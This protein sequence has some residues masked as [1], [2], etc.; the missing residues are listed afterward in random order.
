MCEYCGCQDV[1][2]IADL[3]REHDAVVALIAEVR[4]AFAAGDAPALAGL[5]RRIATVLEPHTAVEEEGLFPLLTDDFPDHVAVL[6]DEH[7]RVEAVLAAAQ[8]GTPADPGWPAALMDAMELLREHIL[9]EQDGV[10]P[11]ALTT[12]GGA[13]WDVVDA[14]RA[15]VGVRVPM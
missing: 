13:D 3:T 11:A 14:V 7:R 2:A 5:A 12:L 8:D 15:R 1:T 10:F 6:R 9:K 4:T